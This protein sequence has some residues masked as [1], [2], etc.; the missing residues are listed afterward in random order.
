MKGKRPGN[1]S[2]SSTAFILQTSLMSP[3][4]ASTTPVR[5][6]SLCYMMSQSL[7]SFFAPGNKGCFLFVTKKVS[8]Q[9][10]LGPGLKLGYSTV[11]LCFTTHR[12]DYMGLQYLGLLS[13]ENDFPAKCSDKSVPL[14]SCF[15]CLGLTYLPSF[16]FSFSFDS[17]SLFHDM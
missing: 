13:E 8:C 2:N 5:E 16:D 9:T 6:N 12:T 10:N 15:L 11:S 14:L 3:F 4:S 1:V 7:S 17:A